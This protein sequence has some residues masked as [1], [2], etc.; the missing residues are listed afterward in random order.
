MYGNT[1]FKQMKNLY[2]FFLMTVS[3]LIL[4][5]CGHSDNLERQKAFDEMM[6]IHDEV[7]PEISTINKLARQLKKKIG[8]TTNQD[9]VIMMKATLKRL[10]DAEEGMMDWMHELDVPGKKI[11]DAKAIEY[12]KKEKDKI[13]IVSQKMKKSIE[14]GKSLLGEK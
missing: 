5:N 4:V 11:E 7:M 2:Y 8:L 6:E 9:S 14:S 13:S 1:K 3:F 12:M 10:E